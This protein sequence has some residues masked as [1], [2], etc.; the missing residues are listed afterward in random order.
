[1]QLTYEDSGSSHAVDVGE[2][3][4]L[5]LPE[6]PTTAYRWETEGDSPSLR[7]LD[8]HFDGVTTPRGAPG[9]RVFTFEAVRPGNVQLRLAKRRSWETN[10]SD[11]FVIDLDITPA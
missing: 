3:L 1:M 7:Q 10:A 11:E 9:M 6:N 8:D 5:T 4:T 2:Q